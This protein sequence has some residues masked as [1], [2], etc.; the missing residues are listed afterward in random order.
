MSSNAWKILSMSAILFLP[1]VCYGSGKFQVQLGKYNN[2]FG[3]IHDGRCCSGD[4][5]QNGCLESCK[6]FFVGCLKHYE[7]SFNFPEECTF[8]I[9][10]SSIFTENSL[11]FELTDSLQN[12]NGAFFE[13]PFVF[14][15]LQT[16]TLIIEA[17]NYPDYR[18]GGDSCLIERVVLSGIIAPGPNWISLI[19]NGPTALLQYSVRVLCDENYHGK[20]CQKFC[21]PRDDLVGHYRC[22]TNGDRICHEGWSGQYC[23]TA[24]CLQGCHTLHGFCS[25][26]NECRCRDGWQGELCDQCKPYPG[27]VHGTCST[28]WQCNCDRKWGGPLCDQDLDKCGRLQPCMQGAVCVNSPPNDYTCRCPQGYTGKNCEIAQRVCD[29][30]PCS[31]GGQCLELTTGFKCLCA[32]GWTGPQCEENLDDCESVPCQHGGTCVDLVRGFECLCTM[33]WQ[34]PTC[35][36]DADECMGQ[37]CVHAFRCRNL[38]GDYLCDCQPGWT[39]KN[40]DRNANDCAGHCLNGATCLDLINSFMCVCKP[41]FTGVECEVNINECES[42]P[43]MHNGQCMDKV[44]GYECICR[45]GFTG[46]NCQ[47]DD[48][49]CDP[50]PC[51]NGASCF[52][53]YGDYFC[54]CREGYENR[55]CSALKIPCSKHPCEVLDSCTIRVPLNSSDGGFVLKPSNVC[56]PHGKCISLNEDGD[57]KCA[58][59]SGYVGAYCH[60]NVND[61]LSSPCY[62]GGTCVDGLNFFQCVCPL[63]WEGVYCQL[64][65]NECDTSP[66]R[67]NGTCVDLH[68]DY[69]CLCPNDWK[70]KSCQSRDSHCS[71]STC[72]NAGTCVETSDSFVCQCMSGFSGPTCRIKDEN[73]CEHHS[74]ENGATCVPSGES[75]LCICKEGYDGQYCENNVDDCHLNPCYNGGRCIDGVNWFQCQCA[76]GFA[77]P[78]CRINLDECLSN[79]CAY[80]STCMDGI[81]SYTCLCPAGR[82]GPTCSL[83]FGHQIEPSRIM[84]CKVD[85]V[86]MSDG[87]S[88]NKDCN[89]CRCES[90]VISCS[91]MECGQDACLINSPSLTSVG[92]TSLPSII[93]TRTCPEHQSCHPVSDADCLTPPCE[94]WGVCLLLADISR[95]LT[96]VPQENSVCSKRS[97]RCIIL[98]I[99]FSL[100]KLPL[101]V[102]VH[103]ICS[104]LQQLTRLQDVTRNQ[105]LSISCTKLQ[106]AKDTIKVTMEADKR[107]SSQ[108]ADHVVETLMLDLDEEFQEGSLLSAIIKIE[109]I[110]ES[111]TSKSAKTGLWLTLYMAALLIVTSIGC[112]GL[113]IRRFIRRQNLQIPPEP[114]PFP[115]ADHSASDNIYSHAPSLLSTSRIYESTLPRSGNYAKMCGDTAEGRR[116]SSI[117]QLKDIGN[118]ESDLEVARYFELTLSKQKSGHKGETE[119]YISMNNLDKT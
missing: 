24:I 69:S 91:K 92:N 75:Y 6:T 10:N 113:S 45:Q 72:Y 115:S 43:C 1:K 103:S 63:G 51:Q 47:L 59:S 70:G 100:K 48:D 106:E 74:C 87:S 9:G 17:K 28:P 49:L 14:G 64:N 7:T 97:G 57:F 102:T 11:E 96:D 19:H 117:E 61:C 53:L 110:Y 4:K 73:V 89:K 88:W 31:H 44:D 105:P 86:T 116:L 76:E 27:C 30:D 37:P 35:Q 99:T 52:N 112:I 65:T 25:Y 18:C 93:P 54:A 77:G 13:F 41:G 80:G 15:W 38:V 94:P 20:D 68:A 111:S 95:G 16:Y 42:N 34:G 32:P 55:N 60:E 33:Q 114:P 2:M 58:C 50:N 3:E 12:G 85:G 78:D 82:S 39:G 84:S 81:N 46:N 104:A 62:N 26:P 23:D 5:T 83:V 29:S 119:C 66:C 36:F 107:I 118:S 108:F 8:G 101:G 40:C 22:D 98:K 67:N 56:G 90:G 21:R 79:P 109:R 71:S